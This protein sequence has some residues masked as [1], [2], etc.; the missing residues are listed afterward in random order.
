MDSKKLASLRKT[1]DTLIYN[2]FIKKSNLDFGAPIFLLPNKFSDDFRLIV[3]SRVQNNA[4]LGSSR[5]IVESCSD[6]V[7]AV[8]SSAYHVTQI[9]L[10]KCYYSIPLSEKVKQSGLANLISPLGVFELQRA[11]TGNKLIPSFL[12][13]YFHVFFAD[14]FIGIDL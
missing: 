4:I 5:P 13:N 7:R 9:D 6:I 3:D 2:N 1:L 12:Y 14:D 8:A 11:I 10:S